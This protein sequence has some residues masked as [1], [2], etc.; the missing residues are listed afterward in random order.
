MLTFFSFVI[1][2]QIDKVARDILEPAGT[3]RIRSYENGVVIIIS[4]SINLLVNCLIFSVSAFSDSLHN[5]RQ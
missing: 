2:A 3:S 1:I 5:V 4:L